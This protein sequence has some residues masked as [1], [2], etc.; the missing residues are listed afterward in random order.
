MFFEKGAGVMVF[1]G[2][3]ALW[4]IAFALAMLAG[5]VIYMR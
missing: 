2:D 4:G 1:R 3:L 5:Y